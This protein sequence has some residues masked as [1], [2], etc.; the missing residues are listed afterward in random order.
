MAAFSSAR[1]AYSRFSFAFLA[2]GF[3]FRMTFLAGSSLPRAVGKAYGRLSN[4]NFGT[5]NLSPL[6]RD[7]NVTSSVFGARPNNWEA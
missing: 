4:V 6:T 3:D 5:S 7:D 2:S 1:F